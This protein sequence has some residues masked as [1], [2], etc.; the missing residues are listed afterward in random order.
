LAEPGARIGRRATIPSMGEDPVAVARSAF[1]R[2]SWRE[3]FNRYRQAESSGVA[4]DPDDLERLAQSAWWIWRIDDSV[5]ARER[6]YSAYRERGDEARA[7]YEAVWLARD[8]FMRLR[9]AIGQGWFKRAER[10]LDGKPE[11]VEHA[12]LEQ[13]RS[14]LAAGEGDLETAVECAKRAAELGARFDDRDIQARAL[15]NQGEALVAQGRVGEGMALFDEAT[16][17]AVSGELSPMATGIVYCNTIGVCARMADYRRAMEWTEAAK[18][19]C[20]RQAISGFPGVCRV[21]RAE[22]VRL[23]GAWPE[24]EREAR[25]ASEELAEHGLLT[26]AAMAFTEIGLIRLRMGDLPAAEEAFRQAHELGESPQPGLA[27]ISLAMGRRDAADAQLRRALEETSGQLA[28]ARLLPAAVEV[29]VAVGDREAARAAAAEL[30]EIATRYD[31]VMLH[32]SAECAE[33]QVLLA[34]RKAPGAI[35]RLRR[36]L[37]HW[38]DAEAPYEM[39]RTCEL[40]GLALREAG[41]KDA[42]MLELRAA[43]ALF[44]R[45]GA[46]LDARRLAELLDEEPA[47]THRVV[48]TFMFTDIVG[49]TGLVEAIG[50]DAWE[51]VRRWHDRALRAAFVAHA[52]EEVDH[53]GDGFFL[54][55]PDAGPALECAVAIQRLLVEHR[56]THGF[57]PRVRIGLHLDEATRRDAGYGGRGV[58]QAARIGAMAEG[59]EIMATEDTIAAAG[60]A[61]TTSEP[62]EVTLKGISDRV[63]VVFVDWRAERRPSH[64]GSSL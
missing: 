36:A 22:I 41:D 26:Y 38:R 60:D 32:A 21:H 12:Y 19:W 25:V 20:E 16:V 17:T 59:G 55:F 2:H 24:A 48:R 34:E 23:R 30:G 40:L 14:A 53:A 39:A 58:H 57:A 52:G 47:P 63:R 43:R 8:H 37:G 9:G 62:R 45:L 46:V 29:S 42:A 54:A 3:A 35:D 61:W 10:L 50:D 28:R 15:T 27:L 11:S 7:A 44:D 49:S 56:K 51:D 6:A 64:D 4:L 1:V 18:R 31:T 13:M 33:G 5:Q